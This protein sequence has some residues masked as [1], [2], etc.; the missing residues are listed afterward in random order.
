MK[1]LATPGNRSGS[2][3]S[4]RRYRYTKVLDNCKHAIR[5]LWRRNGSFVARVTVEDDAGRKA[6]KWVLL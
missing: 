2:S 4:S 6:V 1:R 3:S 5:G